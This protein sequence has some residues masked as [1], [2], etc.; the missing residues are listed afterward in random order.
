M[1]GLWWFLGILALIV[2]LIFWL[3]GYAKFRR[4]GRMY[5]FAGWNL[6]VLGVGGILLALVS[7]LCGFE[8]VTMA[9]LQYYLSNRF[10][11]EVLASLK[12]LLAYAG[13]QTLNLILGGAFL[14]V[15]GLR[16]RLLPGKKKQPKKW[17]LW[18]RYILPVLSCALLSDPLCRHFI[19]LERAHRYIAAQ[20]FF[21]TAN[22]ADMWHFHALAVY[23]LCF[24]VPWFVLKTWSEQDEKGYWLPLALAVCYFLILTLRPVLGV[25][26]YPL[27]VALIVAVMCNCFDIQATKK[28]RAQRYTKRENE[29]LDL[30]SL[31]LAWADQVSP[32]EARRMAGK[33]RDN[34]DSVPARDIFE[35][36]RER[37]QEEE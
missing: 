10:R 12:A 3:D 37:G 8:P 28:K 14:A 32:D 19:D 5:V 4:R 11:W 23:I 31:D 35:K 26:L 17:M 15:L 1:Y 20:G 24:I 30:M 2:G 16:V 33:M 9:E 21:L 13:G 34:G 6:I 29:I 25:M 36:L 27:A 22:P 7:R 18:I